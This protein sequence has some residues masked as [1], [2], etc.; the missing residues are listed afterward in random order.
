M[1]E[2]G[3]DMRYKAENKNHDT[4]MLLR[5]AL[6]T[7]FALTTAFTSCSRHTNYNNKNYTATFEMKSIADNLN[8]NAQDN[9]Q[10][11]LRTRLA[12]YRKIGDDEEKLA[13]SIDDFTYT[14]DYNSFST[15][16]VMEEKVA[17]DTKILEHEKSKPDNIETA[18]LH[19]T[20]KKLRRCICLAETQVRR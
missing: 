12:D 10:N 11:Y 6:C 18:Y 13:N 5:T 8:N 3:T 19:S 15:V 1:V 7:G 16:T 17:N 9:F 2:M 20:L 14:R 4:S